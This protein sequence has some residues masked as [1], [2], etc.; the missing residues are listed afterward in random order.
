MNHHKACVEGYDIAIAEIEHLNR[1]VEVMEGHIVSPDKH[2]KLTAQLAESQ[3]RI[4][5]LKETHVKA[6]SE[7]AELKEAL[8]KSLAEMET[9]KRL[10]ECDCP[11]EGHICGI[12]RL[13]RSIAVAKQALKESDGE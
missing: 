5:Q 10:D 3:K 7:I 12:P 8:G 1:Y 6:D 13:R 11:G 4:C 9:W 2:K